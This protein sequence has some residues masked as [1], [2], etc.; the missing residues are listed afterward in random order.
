MSASHHTAQENSFSFKQG[1][2]SVFQSCAA[3]FKE[4]YNTYIQ[5]NGITTAA[6]AS[7]AFLGV[8]ITL[9]A[10]IAK[11][12]EAYVAAPLIAAAGTML[13]L[14]IWGLGQRRAEIE[15]ETDFPAQIYIYRDWEDFSKNKLNEIVE[16]YH[17]SRDYNT[18]Q[19]K[20]ARDSKRALVTGVTLNT[21]M[22]SLLSYT[23]L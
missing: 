9:G 16:K 13:G 12:S 23:I 14:C 4:A 3:P 22:T 17:R 19:E 21:A 11:N 6:I 5:E 1:I 18:A 10:V 20:I 7:N 2:H 8:F 15:H